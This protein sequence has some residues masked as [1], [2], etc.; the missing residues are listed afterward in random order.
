MYHSTSK[1]LELEAMS[2]S[3]SLSFFSFFLI[4]LFSSRIAE[5]LY[6][7]P[8]EYLIENNQSN[9]TTF[10]SPSQSRYKK[11]KRRSSFIGDRITTSE[12]GVVNWNV[13]ILFFL[14]N[15]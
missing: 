7:V 6:P 5:V 13:C 2:S 15:L 14:L 3:F 12:N 8:D 1:V 10:S 4:Y 11:Q 9:S